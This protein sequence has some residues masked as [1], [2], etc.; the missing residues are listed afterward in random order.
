MLVQNPIALDDLPAEPGSRIV[1]A[2][3]ADAWQNGY[4][5]LAAVRDAASQL[6]ENARKAYAAA[7]E[8]GYEEGRAA[9]ALEASR[10]VRD[11]TLAVDGYLAKLEN[12]IGALAISVVRRMFG[13]LD[14]ADLV[15]RAAAQALTDFR[16]QKNLTVTVH[17]T[18]ADR[19]R[20]ALD[21]VSGVAVTVES[22]PALD[23]GAC[24]VASAFAVVDASIDVQ[25]R[26][27]AA[28]LASA[29]G[30]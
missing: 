1:R 6:E 9:G 8:K 28:E 25:L 20:T 27:L 5:F 23:E 24:V 13:E 17:P 4:E 18:A 21:A 2:A 22:N 12:E 29:N 14:V 10:L 26:A 16:Q 3:E 7:Y 30:P 19:V 11:T 15:A